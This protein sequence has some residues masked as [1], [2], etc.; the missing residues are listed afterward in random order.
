MEVTIVRLELYQYVPP[1]TPLVDP[2]TSQPLQTYQRR[3]RP[4]SVPVPTPVPKAIEDSPP[5]SSPSSDPV[6]QIESNLPFVIRK[7]EA[8]SHPSS[9]TWELVPLPPK[10]SLVRS[11]WLYTLKIG[12]DGKIDRFKARLVAEGY[13]QIF[14][15]DYNDTFLPVAKMAPVR[16]LVSIAAI[17]L[18]PLHQHD[19]KN[20]FLHGDLE[21][22]M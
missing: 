12:L 7:G 4:S 19:I 22:E 1:D 9:G 6:P 13:T 10:K 15:L 21:D 8:S 17:Q 2:P 20:A 3:P 18:W 5:T 11:R 16:L 14:G